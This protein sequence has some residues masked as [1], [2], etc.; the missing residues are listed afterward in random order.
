[1]TLP[2]TDADRQP[3]V[4]NAAV[5]AGA[6]EF[7]AYTLTVNRIGEGSV[8]RVPDQGAYTYLDQVRLTA[9][10]AEGWVSTGWSGDVVTTTNPLTITL[11]RTTVITP[12]SAGSTVL[13]PLPALRSQPQSKALSTPIPFLLAIPIL[14]MC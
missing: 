1:M 9:E 5:D 12:P 8:Q 2:A 4:T 13:P 6:Y 3:R 14:A 10:P 11:S 7:Q